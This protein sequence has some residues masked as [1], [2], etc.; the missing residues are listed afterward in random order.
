MQILVT[1]ET[2]VL[3][4]KE[5]ELDIL[6]LRFDVAAAVAVFSPGSFVITDAYVGIDNKVGLESM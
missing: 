4:C 1:K 3:L 2:L 5:D 6:I